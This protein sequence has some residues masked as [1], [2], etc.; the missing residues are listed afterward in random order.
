MSEFNR[1]LCSFSWFFVFIWFWTF[2]WLGQRVAPFLSV[3]HVNLTQMLDRNLSH[4][5]LPLLY[6]HSHLTEVDAIEED[7]G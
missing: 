7:V 2:G 6:S 3:Q 4:T 5:C 1:S